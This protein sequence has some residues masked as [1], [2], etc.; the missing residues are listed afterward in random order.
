MKTTRLKDLCLMVMFVFIAVCAMMFTGCPLE[1]NNALWKQVC[2]EK[3]F[4]GRLKTPDVPQGVTATAESSSSITVSW[5]EVDG[6][7]RYYI[8]RSSRASGN[9][10]N[11][12][13]TYDT[14]YTD[15]ELSANTTYYYKVTAVNRSGRESS[16]SATA[17]AKT[18][19]LDSG[20]DV[21]DAPAG[22]TATAAS[23]D[24]I[25]VSW[26]MVSDTEYYTIY[27]SSS[28][29]GDYDF[30][31]DIDDTEYTDTGLSAGTTYYYKVSASNY[32][33]ESSQSAYASATT[34][35]SLGGGSY[36]VT[37]NVNSGSGTAPSLQ[38][39]DLGS[40]ITLPSGS[41]L[42]R[43]GYMF[44][45]WNTDASGT[46]T[47]YSA[48]S[49]YTVTGDVTL[50]AKWDLA[51]TVT[52]NANGAG[53]T[54]PSAQTAGSGSSITLP[55]ESGLSRSGYIFGGW[56]TDA[57][58]TGTNYSAGSSYTVTGDV[59]LY[60][61]WEDASTFWT[62]KFE[63]N[64]GSPIG[65][66]VVLK[67]TA[68]SRPVPDPTKTGY[69]FDGW[70]SNAGLTVVYNFSSIVIGNITLYAKWDVA[71]T[72]TF[73]ANGATGGTAPSAQTA[74]SGSSITLPSE[75]GLSRSGYTFG[76]WNT[77][78]S[79]TGTNYNAGSSYTVT[80][81]VTLYA[82]W[83]ASDPGTGVNPIPLTANTWADGSITSSTSGGAVWYSFNVVSGTTY[84]VWWNDYYQSDGDGT[85][86]LDVKVSAYYS[87]GTSI[88]TG[89]DSGWRES[90][91]FTASSSGTVKIKVEPYF[92][93][94]TGT[95]AVAYSTTN[96]RPG[97]VSSN[98]PVDVPGANL[99]A[100]LSW[101]Q[102]NAVSNVDYTVEVSA[103][104]SISPTTLSYSGKTNI[105][106]T[107]RGT[108]A[109]R[110]VS[111]SS[112]GSMFTVASGVTLVLDN[113]ITL[114]GRSGNTDELVFVSGGGLVMNTGSKITGNTIGSDDG[115][116]GGVWVSGTF[117]M[118][119]GTISGNTGSNG[120]GVYVT[121]TFTMNGGTISGNTAYSQ[122]FAY[123]GGVYVRGTFTMS[124]GT[125]SGNTAR[126]PINGAPT[127]GGGVYV[128]GSGTF[129][130]TGGTIYGYSASDTVNSNVVT[131]RSAVNNNGHAVYVSSSS[132]KYKDTTAGTGVNMS[133]NGNNGTFGGS[134]DN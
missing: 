84:Y 94:D 127:Y 126:N 106:I 79:G 87:S 62:V 73:N 63:T 12:D 16:R 80:G 132:G 122:F 54:A 26:N 123:G 109:V 53:G 95:F 30:V 20:G 60:A 14:E 4:E 13:Y 115:L 49:S 105:G 85:K 40:A 5:K 119:G 90:K 25:T 93:S 39:V 130:K 67:N 97:G 18:L 91:Q 86:T 57:S 72:V 116:P 69:T 78:A 51:Y 19:P 68:V 104:E 37:F 1:N 34:T 92:S 82:K 107:L 56:N 74:G 110:T 8:Y 44:G 71:Y 75:S 55:S 7:Y 10:D 59:T 65:D 81:N 21:P 133:Y 3:G 17:S 129:T 35:L 15:T 70:F 96:T 131:R 48:G 124:G 58:G 9:Y 46:G 112:N 118:N 23:S 89:V 99:A 61:K 120:G 113:N 32:Y 45:G 24:S 125:I 134:W 102:T 41:G 29:S 108:G 77:D 6:A 98:G 28:A 50:Y 42:S 88:F 27:R 103:N 83:D 43:S 64:G 121:G 2:K 111:L 47:N 52:F 36:T 22:V 66:V 33:G 38:T 100:K 128:S 117:T 11:I 76:G 31:V 101:L 114:Q